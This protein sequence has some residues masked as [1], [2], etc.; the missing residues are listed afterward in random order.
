MLH[1]AC[2]M[3]D[4]E[5]TGIISKDAIAPPVD[6]HLRIQLRIDTFRYAPSYLSNMLTAF[7]GCQIFW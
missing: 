3:G 2:R 6:N 7:R 5:E 4:A 1:T